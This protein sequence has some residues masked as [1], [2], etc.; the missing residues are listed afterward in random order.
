MKYVCKRSVDNDS[1]L[2][3]FDFPFKIPD[4]KLPDV[5][6][7]EIKIPDIKLSDIKIPKIDIPNIG[8]VIDDAGKNIQT[9]LDNAK[10]NIKK[11]IGTVK[12]LSDRS[13]YEWRNHKW[14][15]RKRNEYGKWIYDYGNGFPGENKLGKVSDPNIVEDKNVKMYDPSLVEKFLNPIIGI[16]KIALGPSLDEKAKGGEAFVGGIIEGLNRMRVAASRFGEEVDSETGF[17][18][19]RSDQGKQYDLE[20]SNPGWENKDGGGQN[21]CPCCSVAYDMRRRGYDVV[22]KETRSGLSNEQMVSMYKD[23]VVHEISADTED[24]RYFPTKDGVSVRNAGLSNAVYEQMDKE[25]DNTRGIM[26]MEWYPEGNGGHA[27]AYEKENGKT[28]I[29]DAQCREKLELYEYTDNASKFYYYR[30]DNLEPDLEQI[31]KVVE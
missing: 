18:K 31:K 26:F 1:E 23:P 19:K 7:P 22:A 10:N 8:K 4:I 27:V 24:Y 17:S 6:I 16:G 29:Y 3:H 13:G 20:N 2:Y 14:I 11:S 25:P 9:S 15:A 21:N 28:Y 12:G 5:K 30:T